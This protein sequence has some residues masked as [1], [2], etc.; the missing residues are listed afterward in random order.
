MKI[1]SRRKVQEVDVEL[2]L[3]ALDELV[4][5][6]IKHEDDDEPSQEEF[7][8]YHED[9]VIQ[10]AKQLGYRVYRC[11]NTQTWG[12]SIDGETYLM[13]TEHYRQSQPEQAMKVM[14]DTIEILKQERE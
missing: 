5:A 12:F 7:P 11:T 8:F 1:V 2:D 13:F 6:D 14:R 4:N 9:W 10:G 3:K